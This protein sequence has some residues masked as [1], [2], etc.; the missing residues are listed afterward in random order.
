M[1]NKLVLLFLGCAVLGYA[2]KKPAKNTVKIKPKSEFVA[3]LMSK[4]TLDEKLGQ[5]NLPTSGDITTGQANSSNV[6][7]NI[8]EGKVGGLFNI[9]SVQKIKEVQKIAVEKS[10]LKIPLLFGMDVIHGYETTFP[11]PLGL[12]CTWD[13]GLIERSAQIAAKEASADGINWTFSPMVDI[14]RDPRWG[15]VS[16]GSGEDPYLGGQIAKAMVNGYQQHDLSK[17]NSILACVKHFALYGAPEAGRDYNTVDMSHIRMFNDYFPPYKAAVDAGVGSVM[18]S[19]NEVDGIPATGN[20]WLMTDVLRKQWGFKGFVVTDFTGIPEMIEHGMGNLQDVSALALNAG[21]EMDM[22][23]EGFLG[24]LKKSLDE[25]RVSIETIDNAVKLILEAK[26]DL[27]LFEDPYKYCDEKRAKTE[28]FTMDSRKEARQI[29][30][31]SLVLLKNQNQLLPLKKSGTIG[32]IGPLADAKENM[33]GTWSVATKMENA[34]SLLAGIKEV[35]GAGT[36]VLYAK[37]SNLDY[38]ET[39]ETNATMFGKTLHRDGRSKEELLAEALKVAEQSDVIVAALGE[40]AEMSGESSSRTNL[41]IPQAQKDLLNALL[42]TGKPVVLVLFDGRPLVITDEEK[43]VPAILNAWFAGT[44]AGYAIADVLFGDVNPSGK[45]TT[46]F[47]RSVGQLPIYY[48]HKNTGRPLSNTEG[49]FEKFRSNYIDERNEPLFPFGFGL[50]YTTF[51]YSNLKISSDKMN[52]SG[53]LKVTVDVTNT[54]NFDGKETVQLY[55]RDLVGSVTRPVRELKGFQKIA[56]KKGEK[57]TVSFDITVEDLKFYNSDLQFVAEPGQFDV[58]VGGNS[59][60]D[61]KV[62]FELTK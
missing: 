57:Q 41:Q 31:Q 16:E 62:S 5:L 36:K 22:V 3:E 52:A 29:A 44:E 4:M 55:I 21:V 34:V 12:S 53:K 7:K 6:A 56:L 47:P 42:K 50:S 26:Y 18:A 2:Q 20:K 9:K 17:N 49:K 23:G 43:T 13:M 46:T 25:K 51:D 37:G 24:T 1:K 58:F 38:D 19:F 60:A 10:R 48:A 8:A 59:T 54:G 28:I 35:A 15:R 45:L 40:S 32:L 14:S 11:I 27:G 61:K 39:F 30:A 33:P